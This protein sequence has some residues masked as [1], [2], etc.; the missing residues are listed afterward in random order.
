EAIHAGL[1]NIDIDTSTLVDLSKPTLAEQ[2]RLNC[3]VGIDIL[4][5][6]RGAQPKGVEISVGGE[7]GEVGTQNSTVD[8]LE[9]YMDGFNQAL[10]RCLAVMS[11]IRNQYVTTLG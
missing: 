3:E 1:Y 5:V 2:Q 4:K 9:A 6:V 7:I 11:Y 8:E 10:Q